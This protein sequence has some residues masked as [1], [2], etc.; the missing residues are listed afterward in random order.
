[1]AGIKI[2]NVL[3]DDT[4]EEILDIFHQAPAG[5]VVFVL[6]KQSKLFRKE[7]HFSLFAKDAK[8][9]E[10][11]ISVMTPNTAVAAMA[12][13]FGFTVLAAKARG[14]KPKAALASSP[15]PQ[16]DEADEVSED[17]FQDDVKVPGG[18]RDQI[19]GEDEDPAPPSGFHVEDERGPVEIEDEDGQTLE[20]PTNE[21]LQ[22]GGDADLATA[23]LAASKVDG[24]RAGGMARGV[25]IPKRAEKAQPV[26]VQTPPGEEGHDYIETMWRAKVQEGAAGLNKLFKRT[27]TSPSPT[28]STPRRLTS[29]TTSIAILTASV[30]VLIGALYFVR[31]SATIVLTPTAKTLQEDVSIQASD[32]FSSIDPAFNKLPGQL[33]SVSKTATQSRP[34]SGS[35]T[36]ASKARGTITVYNEY[37]SSP[38]QLIAT[39]RFATPSGLIFRTLQSIT[40]PGSSVANG[41]LVPGKI[42]VDV[43]ADKPGTDY[44]V[45]AGTF[46]VAAFQEKGDTDRVQKIYGKSTNAMS[47]GANGPSKVITAD[48]YQGALQAATADATKQITDAVAAQSDLQVLPVITPTITSTTSTGK[49]DDAADSVAVTVTANLHTVAFRQDDLKQLLVAAVLKKDRLVVV[50]DQLTL[51]YADPT[52][53]TATGVLQFTV[54]VTGPGYQPLDTEAI[55]TD[56]AGKNTQEARDYF[57]GKADVESATIS[58]SPFWQR[59]IPTDTAH[60][61]IQLVYTPPPPS[62]SP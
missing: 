11:T 38:Q 20:R 28:S 25:P 1:M 47:G 27:P 58:M 24:V 56:I 26:P 62:T 57:A 61:K 30:L 46:I 7:E 59:H 10:K 8:T 36:V 29:K 60:V 31:G 55:A 17:A 12:R 54:H 6:P 52:F 37:S 21:E 3:K 45:P 2:I 9:G 22:Y 44:D 16:D 48:D 43:V 18:E 53:N 33:V 39:T 50:P 4:L 14:A 49:T 19:A 51:S 13:A 42:D 35:R 5:E 40:V 41:T 34:S 32:A 23:T 15:P